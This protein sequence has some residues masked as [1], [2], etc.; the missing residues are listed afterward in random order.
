MLAETDDPD[1]LDPHDLRT[2]LACGDRACAQG[3]GERLAQVAHL[4]GLCVPATVQLDLLE[5]ERLA[6]RDLGGAVALW[7]SLT[8]SLR[9]RLRGLPQGYERRA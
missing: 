7:W 9:E 6:E 3:H 5:V 2:L 8:A 4:L 1:P